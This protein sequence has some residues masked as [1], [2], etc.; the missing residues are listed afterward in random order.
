MKKKG[1]IIGIISAIGVFIIPIIQGVVIHKIENINYIDALKKIFTNIFNF[2][3]S[4]MNFKVP[5]WLISLLV[6]LI[7]LIIKIYTYIKNAVDKDEY[8]WEKYK[9]EKYEGLTYTWKYDNYLGEKKIKD[10]KPI[11]ECGCDL[12][13]KDSYNN[14]HKYQ[15]YLVCPNCGKGYNNNFMQNRQAVSNIIVYKYNKMIK[16]YM[17]NN[18]SDSEI[19]LNELTENEIAVLN[20]FYIPELRKYTSDK[21]VINSSSN[22]IELLTERGILKKQNQFELIENY[23]SNGTSYK[24]TEEAIKILNKKKK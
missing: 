14:Y 11:C 2:V 19:N 1:K 9:T 23:T 10:L 13:I 12:I 16:K 18:N 8:E 20:K 3:I 17:E 7:L 5:I 6:I 22:A 21:R 4:I 15:G 24:L